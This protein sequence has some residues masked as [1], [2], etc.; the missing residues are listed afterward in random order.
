MT[1]PTLSVGKVVADHDAVIRSVHDPQA[2]PEVF[3]PAA[4]TAPVDG[5]RMAGVR[6]PITVGLASLLPTESGELLMDAPG[7]P[8]EYRSF[9]LAPGA[10]VDVLR[11]ADAG[12]D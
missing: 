10:G 3:F 4:A 8:Q 11:S 6:R 1:S 5:L 12:L 7:C 2:R 9:V